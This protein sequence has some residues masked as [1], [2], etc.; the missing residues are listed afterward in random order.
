VN[1][2]FKANWYAK[3]NNRVAQFDSVGS[4]WQFFPKIWD[5]GLNKTNS[6]VDLKWRRIQALFRETVEPDF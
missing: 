5:V 1:K 6:F 4:S 3:Q 2:S